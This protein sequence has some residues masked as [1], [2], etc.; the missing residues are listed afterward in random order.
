MPY[1]PFIAC[2]AGAQSVVSMYPM[3]RLTQAKTLK[4]STSGSSAFG[5]HHLCMCIAMTVIGM[6]LCYFIT[7]RKKTKTESPE[8][9]PIMNR[10]TPTYLNQLQLLFWTVLMGLAG[11]YAR[12]ASVTDLTYVNHSTYIEITDCLLS[13]TGEL[14]IPSSLEGLPVTTIGLSAFRACAGLTAVTLPDS[15]TTIGENAFRECSGLTAIDIPDSVTSMGK[16]AFKDCIGLQDVRLSQSLTSINRAA[17]GG[18]TSLQLIVVPASVNSFSANAFKNCSNLADII[19]LGGLLS[20]GT[21][22][23]D[24]VSPSAVLYYPEGATGLDDPELSAL[25]K[26]NLGYY[27]PFKK[28]LIKR[29][30]AHDLD[31]EADLSGDGVSLV[32]AFARNLDPRASNS[33]SP[34]FSTAGGQL[35]IDYYAASPWVRYR[36]LQS[37]NLKD[38]TDAGVSITAPNALGRVTASIPMSGGARFI[39]MHSEF[40]VLYVSPAGSGS[41][42][43]SDQPG[44]IDAALA[45][46]PPGAT[47]RLLPGTY[48]RIDVNV[49]GMPEKP[50]TLVSDSTDPA[51]YA[52]IDGGNTTGDNGN[53]GMVIS[54]ASWLVLENL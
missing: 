41:D 19:F 34:D 49:S 44:N 7:G 33:T 4:V 24:G 3:P 12:A 36:A 38:W 42:Y 6:V 22:A 27:T 26:V 1:V 23:F 20:I 39:K 25:S 47:I 32:A 46:A 17:F 52:V 29:D 16:W 53:Q 40:P 43:R 14:V 54:N 21:E 11:S 50:I 18:C 8:S 15:L 30:L 13:A 35:A 48:P 37:T 31:P 45:A 9:T 28:W 51:Q 10:L 5:V 2:E